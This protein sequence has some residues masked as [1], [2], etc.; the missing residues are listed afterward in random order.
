LGNK[1]CF[2]LSRLLVKPSFPEAENWS[3]GPNLRSDIQP[4][5]ESS[6]AEATADSVPLGRVCT[7]IFSPSLQLSLSLAFPP[8]SSKSFKKSYYNYN[9]HSIWKI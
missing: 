6:L 2:W 9:K 7:D 4:G 3:T 1:L 8:S 5:W